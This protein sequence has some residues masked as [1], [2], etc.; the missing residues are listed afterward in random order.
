MRCLLL[1]DIDGTLVSGGPAKEAFEAAL[2]ETFGTAG[3]E[4]STDFSGK[5]DRQIARELLR[6][7]G[8]SDEEIDAG[9]DDLFARYLDGLERLL[10]TDP[11]RVLPGVEPLV[12]VLRARDEIALGLLT[13][14]VADGA[15]LKLSASGLFQHFPVGSFGS[16]SEFRE[17]L[18]AVAVARA[19]S[20]WGVAF[21]P[22]EVIVIGD[23][24]RDVSCGRAHGART[25][26]V[27]TGRFGAGE[28]REAGAD[29]VLDDFRETERVV[30]LLSA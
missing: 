29:Y 8:R 4:G 14:N 30:E 3:P 7:V 2:I 27:A 6:G 5:T 12:E 9:L 20:R 18:P 10:P 15:R 24:P 19:H 23:T 28:L 13:G 21:A 17:E 26:A 1:F 25:V 16:D 11:M 22:D